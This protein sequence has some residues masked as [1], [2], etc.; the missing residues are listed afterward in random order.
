MVNVKFIEDEEYIFIENLEASW[1][2]NTRVAELSARGYKFEQFNLYMSL[3]TTGFYP[4][5]T[6]N[7]INYTDGLD[8]IPFKLTDGYINITY[9]DSITVRGSF[10]VSLEDNFNGAETRTIVGGFGINIH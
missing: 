7:N 10:Q 6:I 5:P 9:I 4:S 2:I 3:Q 1:D 8:F